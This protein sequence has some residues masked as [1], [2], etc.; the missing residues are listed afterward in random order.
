M[1]V[2]STKREILHRGVENIRFPILAISFCLQG[3]IIYVR[4][5]QEKI[6]EE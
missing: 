6:R 4:L 2:D 1:F 5:H 3:M